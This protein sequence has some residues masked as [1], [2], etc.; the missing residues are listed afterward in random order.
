[1][2][3]GY[4]SLRQVLAFTLVSWTYSRS[5]LDRLAIYHSGWEQPGFEGGLA[6]IVAV[7]RRSQIRTLRVRAPISAVQMEGPETEAVAG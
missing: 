4:L 6:Q 1:M 5:Q 7:D 2:D 3:R